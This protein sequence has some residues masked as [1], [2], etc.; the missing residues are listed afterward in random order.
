MCKIIDTLYR[1]STLML[2]SLSTSEI[3]AASTSLTQ[4]TFEISPFIKMFFGLVFVIALIFFVAWITRKLKLMQHFTTGYQIK[5]LATLSLGTREKICLIEVGDKQVLVGV[6]PGRV[7][8]LHVFEEEIKPT[9]AE[10][11]NVNNQFA[12]VF[13]NALGIT[14][15]KGQKS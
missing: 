8:Q 5:N 9:T 12:N 15:S 13:K 6:A 11:T 1:S 14:E 2:I 4:N 7:N 10:T 3:V